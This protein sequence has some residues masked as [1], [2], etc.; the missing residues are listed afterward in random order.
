[1]ARIPELSYSP[2]SA[3]KVLRERF[4]IL[5]A[6]PVQRPYFDPEQPPPSD[7]DVL[8]LLLDTTI[9]SNCT[10]AKAVAEYGRFHARSSSDLPDFQEAVSRGW[11]RTIDGE[12]TR[13]VALRDH[14]SRGNP[15]YADEL[16]AY[17]S[18][19]WQ[20]QYQVDNRGTHGSADALEALLI[21]GAAPEQLPPVRSP[22]WVAAR[23]WDQAPAADLATWELRW[24]VL[25]HPTVIPVNAW[26][27]DYAQRFRD[28]ALSALTCGNLP[29]WEDVEA[30]HGIRET[31]DARVA[32]AA[33]VPPGL[34]G[35][36]LSRLHN[37]YGTDLFRAQ[38]LFALGRLLVMELAHIE[39]GVPPS[40]VAQELV[41]LAMRHP[42]LL[43]VLASACRQSP[44]TLA[45]LILCP[46]A[47]G[48]VCYV[49]A[50]WNAQ[51]R[52]DRDSRQ[53]I[54]EAIQRSLLKDCLEVFESQ[55]LSDLVPAEEYGRL[56]V[57]LHE[58]D[59]ACPD[60]D[61][62]LPI[63]LDRLQRLGKSM[64]TQFL[65][66]VV[67]AGAGNA[68]GPGFVVL[69]KFLAVT[70]IDLKE[71]DAAKVTES[72]RLA[73]ASMEGN[74]LLLDAVSAGVLARIA[75][76]HPERKDAV[77]RPLDVA[78][79]LKAE[80]GNSV[81][82]GQ[83]LRTHIR[84][85][86]RAV[87]G[88]PE[89]VWHELVDALA[90][91][92][93]S[94][95]VARPGENQVDAF[96]FHLDS[97]RRP[98]LLR[99]EVELADAIGRIELA[100][101]QQL[102]VNAALLVNDPLVLAVLLRRAPVSHREQIRDRLKALTPAAASAP[103]FAMQLQ[104]RIEA[105]FDAG[106]PDVAELHMKERLA[107]L[108]DPNSTEARLQTLH[109]DLHLHYLRGDWKEITEAKLP[110]GW[111]KEHA[112]Q[113]RQI[114]DFFCALA[115]L[116]QQPGDA[117]RAAAMFKRL[118]D[119][120]KDPVYAI[121]R[122]SALCKKLLGV[123]EFRT[124]A[125][126]EAAEARRALL[127]A[128]LAIPPTSRLSDLAKAVH[129]PNCA[130]MLMAVGRSPEA[131]HRLQGL[132][133]SERTA[134]SMAYEAVACHRLSDHDRALSLIR[135]GK[136]RFGDVPLL[137]G[138]EEH[139][140]HSAPHPGATRIVMDSEV[141]GTIREAMTLFANLRPRGQ[142]AVIRQGPTPLE[143]ILSDT[144]RDAL[145][146]FERALAFL[147]P[148]KNSFHEDDFNGLLAEF[149]QGRIE[150]LFGWQAHE[151]SP[152]GYTDK[153]NP[154][155]RDFALRHRG[156]DIAVFEA[157]KA[158]R[159]NDPKIGEHLRKLVRSYGKASIFFLVTYSF[160]E[161]S[162]PEMLK[163][164]ETLAG[165]SFENVVSV[166]PPVQMARE[167]ARPA[168]FRGHYRRDGDDITVFFFVIDMLQHKSALVPK[169]ADT[170]KTPTARKPRAAKPPAASRKVSLA[171]AAK[172]GQ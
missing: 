34:L 31:G 47:S 26:S 41:A 8:R 126:D 55:L 87:L 48:W 69:L 144:F 45:D 104:T 92:V 70:G 76:L 150:G 103:A 73:I 146:A 107:L 138:A 112:A 40:P 17:L 137:L 164:M 153:G 5:P 43:E 66:G 79:G 163:A 159:P 39:E 16:M 75:F 10:E 72:Y 155:R 6:E 140:V 145:T 74:D 120:A 24:E 96:T 151:Q 88:Y 81:K 143:S 37:P 99:L 165:Q 52:P 49:V 169:T 95:A 118:Y 119:Q 109:F 56:L 42:D 93:R 170:S 83:A 9:S 132:D 148:P 154:G 172:N 60:A 102:I 82:V 123:N 78:A 149:V 84:F 4:S 130:V 127:E 168:G 94:G 162:L 44:K 36:Y 171:K 33:N 63:A 124:L 85:L 58:L 32:P 28:A 18:W 139:I 64:Q 147:R 108:R 7:L 125:G 11:F 22:E 166:G 142:A 12:V 53:E 23:L 156:E 116:K 14:T 129:V 3:R 54:A 46:Q 152:G 35:R 1:M 101:Q 19:L 141:A 122:L 113:G 114:L 20:I 57:A 135:L 100:P 161:A 167:G 27:A 62:L 86:C 71:D 89:T 2:F 97:M 121:N 15:P 160:R 59:L 30:P 117:V 157:L 105:F 111:P 134:D 38:H 90:E 77:L 128:D 61:P 106:L 68:K 50:S 136:E 131:L 91:A 133:A 115:L 13:A 21:S 25:G 158:S 110:D 67:D 80:G 51:V 29:G 98:P 65:R